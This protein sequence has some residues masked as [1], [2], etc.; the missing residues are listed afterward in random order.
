M[1]ERQPLKE[2]YEVIAEKDAEIEALREALLGVDKW[3]D[4]I[5]LYADKSHRLHP[6]FQ[7]VRDAVRA[8]K[9]KQEME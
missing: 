3:L 9:Q 8:F 5:E 2:W 6:V 7:K 1:Y 4:D